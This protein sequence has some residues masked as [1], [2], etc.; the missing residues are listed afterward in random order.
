MTSTDI[1]L[2][3][4]ANFLHGLTTKKRPGH[5]LEWDGERA[6]VTGSDRQWQMIIEGTL[7]YVSTRDGARFA[8]RE[9][10]LCADL[11]REILEG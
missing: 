3:F 1:V 4:Y 7:G 9:P 8:A 5:T 6:I 11:V 2:M 10:D